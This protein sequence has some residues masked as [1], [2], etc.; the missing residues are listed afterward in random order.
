VQKGATLFARL[1][2]GSPANVRL[3]LWAPGT[4]H[5]EP[6]PGQAFVDGR[7]ARSR[8]AAGQVRLSYRAKTSGVYYLEAK[9]VAPVPDPVQYTLA[10]SRR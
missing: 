8:T 2:P 4:Q 7:V 6:S 10:L 9:L 3:A 1:T 5:V